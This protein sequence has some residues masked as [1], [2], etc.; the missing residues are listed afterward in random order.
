VL[1]R[2]LGREA[3]QRIADHFSWRETALRT[4]AL[5]EEVIAKRTARV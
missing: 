4:Q 5:Y 3:R 2:R 1:R